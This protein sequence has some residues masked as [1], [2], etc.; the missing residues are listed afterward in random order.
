M[1]W[2]CKLFLLHMYVYYRP[3]FWTF[4][5]S[6]ITGS[7]QNQAATVLKSGQWKVQQWQT[8]D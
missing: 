7:F 6:V 2:C 1:P 4:H 5:T 3:D 8:T